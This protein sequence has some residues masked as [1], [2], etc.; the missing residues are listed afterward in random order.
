[1]ARI[2]KGLLVLIYP[3]FF[4]WTW[5]GLIRQSANLSA[6]LGSRHSQYLPS[7]QVL[8]SNAP[9]PNEFYTMTTPQAGDGN[10][11]YALLGVDGS[12]PYPLRFQPCEPLQDATLWQYT[13]DTKG[14]GIF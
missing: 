6:T 5:A 14:G 1:M 12:S 3:F 13:F 2:P 11:L 9:D 4:N 10:C 7:S 8:F